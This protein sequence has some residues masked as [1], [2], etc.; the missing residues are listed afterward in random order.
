VLLSDE[1]QS[2][3]AYLDIQKIRFEDRLDVSFAIADDANNTAVPTFV[4]QPLVENAVKFTLDKSGGVARIKVSAQRHDGMLDLSVE[5]NGPGI[6]T[7]AIEA[8]HG[9]GLR[10][11]RARLEQLYGNNQSIRLDSVPSGGTRVSISIPA[12]DSSTVKPT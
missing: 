10:T 3:R 9:V 5:D 8:G 7:D 11:T 2:V 4:L 6:S 12:S 1:I